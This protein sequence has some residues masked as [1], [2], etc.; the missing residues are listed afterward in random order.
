MKKSGLAYL[1]GTTPA[2]R[3]GRVC[4]GPGDTVLNVLVLSGLGLP[5]LGSF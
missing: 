4:L 5:P 2:G 1:L 3:V